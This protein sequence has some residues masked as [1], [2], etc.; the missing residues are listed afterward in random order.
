MARNKPFL[1]GGNTTNSTV[2]PLF[3]DALAANKVI[4]TRQFSFGFVNKTNSFVDFGTPQ[5]SAMSNSNDLRD[6]YVENDFFWS[7]YS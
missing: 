1:L 6:I 5:M 2:G 4:S 7:A 3:V